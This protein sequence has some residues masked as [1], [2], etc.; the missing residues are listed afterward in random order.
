LKSDTNPVT[1]LAPNLSIPRVP[2]G[3]RLLLIGAILV[4]GLVTLPQSVQFGSVSGLGALTILWC[5]AA[6]GFWA[7]RP[8]LP[9][10]FRAP[11]LPLLLFTVCCFGSML[12]YP[13]GVKGLQ[14][15]AVTVGFFGFILLTARHVEESPELAGA[16]YRALDAA[17]IFAA[18]LYAATV[19]VWGLGND[20][21]VFARS[22]ALF[23]L[24][25]VARQLAR[26]QAGSRSG[27]PLAALLTG[28]IFLSVSRTALVA[29]LALF[30]LAAL[31]R[32]GRRGLFT[33]VALAAL[34]VAALLAAIFLSETMYERFFGYDAT[35]EVAGVTVNASGRRDMWA[36]LL[37]RSQDHILL[38]HGI[39]SSSILVD[40]T[41]ENLGHPHN[42]YL[43]FLYDLGLAGLGSWVAFLGATGL[44]LWTHAH[45]RARAAEASLPYFLTPLLALAAIA[46]S[47]FTDNSAGY[48]FVMA[49]LGIL[50]GCALGLTRAVSR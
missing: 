17:T 27:L 24:F 44:F 23:A 41:F 11:L 46:A 43:R 36:H 34:A 12:W 42:D 21:V 9:G 19:V 2:P 40:N 16:I 49:P 15:V 8:W 20:Q 26:W 37:E 22:F 45:R 6:W 32:G 48:V 28:V 35:L 29:A 13:P 30:P 10:E 4:C 47:M 38:G 14:V 50:I 25:G 3:W 31:V 39:G 1:S 33:T 5:I 18:A 7:A